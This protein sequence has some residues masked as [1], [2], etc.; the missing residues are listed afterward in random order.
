MYTSSNTQIPVFN[1]H[2]QF[3]HMRIG[4]VQRARN[5]GLGFK[6]TVQNIELCRCQ[7]I[8][9]SWNYVVNKIRLIS[10]NP[11]S[12]LPVLAIFMCEFMHWNFYLVFTEMFGMPNAKYG[13]T[14]VKFLEKCRLVFN[15]A[16]QMELC[17]C[18]R[19]YIQCVW[20]KG[21]PNSKG[22]CF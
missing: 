20:Q 5:L 22:Y 12:S 15:T 4:L 13:R 9:I 10:T 8:F 21:N 7:L 6:A 19:A 11:I 3:C 17:N 18:W 16:E 14:K 2:M 1:F